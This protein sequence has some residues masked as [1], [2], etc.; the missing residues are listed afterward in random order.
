MVSL[1]NFR[2]EASLGF[3]NVHVDHVS[4]FVTVLVMLLSKPSILVS[5]ILSL[6][7]LIYQLGTSEIGGF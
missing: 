3:V 5:G 2:W 4:F 7:S 1:S 6:C